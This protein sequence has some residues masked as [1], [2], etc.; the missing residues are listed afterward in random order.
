MALAARMDHRDYRV[1]CALGDGENQEGQIWEAAMAASHFELDNLCAILDRNNLQIDGPTEQ[2]MRIEP[3]A[4]KWRAFGWHVVEI[5]GHDHN[6]ILRSLHEA[7]YVQERPT[8]VL[9]NTVKGKGVS[10]ME[11][12]LSF[13]GRPPNEDEYGK[14]M[15]ELDEIIERAE[16]MAGVVPA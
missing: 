9:A 14:A 2:I 5:D 8:L 15:Q 7:E 4:K 6:D 1:Y 13:H 12:S 16:K 10:F 3:I 11:G